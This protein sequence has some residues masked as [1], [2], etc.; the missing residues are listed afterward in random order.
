MTKNFTETSRGTMPEKQVTTPATEAPPGTDAIGMTVAEVF[1]NEHYRV[2]YNIIN[3]K[4]EYMTIGQEPERWQPV[5]DAV[6]NTMNRLAKNLGVGKNPKADIKEYIFSAEIPQFD[7]IKDY[8]SKCP[9]WD[10][11]DRLTPFFS[12]IPGIT[13][14]QVYWASIWLMSAMAHWLDMENIYGNQCVLT[15]IGSQGDHKTSFGKMLLPPELRDE[16]F[17]DNV[18]LANKFDKEMALTN[19]LIVNIDEIDKYPARQQAELK[20]LITKPM[21][22]G[23]PIYGKVQENRRRWC[24]FMAT[25]NKRHPL[26]DPTGS[27]R[28]ICIEL[29]EGQGINVDAETNYPQLMAQL[30]HMVVDEG[31]RFWFTDEEVARIQEAN[32]P[33]MSN[34]EI[35]K[36]VQACYRKP[37][38]GEES[39]AVSLDEII[40]TLKERFPAIEIAAD[41]AGKIQLGTALMRMGI[42]SHRGHNHTTY[43]LVA[44]A[45]KK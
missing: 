5:T 40:A 42:E 30:K 7:P 34:G 23:R 27:R 35:I 44:K 16:Y 24:S 12:R 43:G 15:L 17:L 19:N 4:T 37:V 31:R 14:E 1:I 2:R 39:K 11:T 26:N 41:R 20:Y 22:N 9:E 6:I 21:V 38:E 10:G 3:R 25:T 36:M 18:N 28:Y 8:L 32:M 13:P 45:T 29:P 33:Y